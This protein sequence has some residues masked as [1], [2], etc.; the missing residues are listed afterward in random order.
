MRRSLRI[1]PDQQPGNPKTPATRRFKGWLAEA[2]VAFL[3]EHAPTPAHAIG[4]A[5]KRDFP[6]LL[7]S[8]VFISIR[9]LHDRGLVHR[10]ECTKCYTVTATREPVHLLCGVCGG[11][12]GRR[13]KSSATFSALER[14]GMTLSPAARSWR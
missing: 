5:L 11:Y 10:V 7:G 6:Q 9:R 2:I 12:G 4:V 3:R 14:T 8:A 13:P 1:L